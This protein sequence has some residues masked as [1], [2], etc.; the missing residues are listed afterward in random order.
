MTQ[1]QRKIFYPTIFFLGA[2]LII[3]EINIYRETIINWM[4]PVGIIIF[5]GIIA[6]IL[7]FKN[8]KKT[9]QY[10]GF[11]LYLYSAMHYVI[12]FGFIACSIFM[13]SNYYFANQNIK[14]ES[15]EIIHTS[16]LASG[17][18]HTVDVKTPTFRINYNGKVKELVFSS[19]YFEKRNFYN[20]V[21][22]E[23]RKGLFGFDILENKKLF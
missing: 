6:S 11:E 21:E 20:N 22:L 17:G 15:F 2:I 8:Y 3:W 13:L 1:K 18:K 12:G 5:V 23:I 19:N 14:T 10:S 9:Y 4:I 7:D 16:S